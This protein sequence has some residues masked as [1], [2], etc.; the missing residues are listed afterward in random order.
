MKTSAAFDLSIIKL[1]GRSSQCGQDST[2][3]DQTTHVREPEQQKKRHPK[4]TNGYA[5]KRARD[6]RPGHVLQR[7]REELRL[8]YTSCASYVFR[9]D[10]A[11][12]ERKA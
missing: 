8:L 9:F 4:R 1:E 6:A 7:E 10:G 11:R 12:F 3:I 2:V 5:H